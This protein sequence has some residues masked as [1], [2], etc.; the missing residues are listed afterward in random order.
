[1][2]R[3][4]LL[5]DSFAQHI[6]T[7]VLTGMLLSACALNA[8]DNASPQTATTMT[9]ATGCKPLKP[10]P[11]IG[12]LLIKESG[13]FHM[14]ESFSQGWIFDIHA[15]AYKGPNIPSMIHGEAA[16]VEIDLKSK[17]LKTD[18]YVS[19]IMVIAARYNPKGRNVPLESNEVHRVI[20]RNGTIQLKNTRNVGNGFG[21]ILAG[22]TNDTLKW[23]YYG[24]N[25]KDYGNPT[26]RPPFPTTFRK[27]QY[28]LENLTIKTAN[29]A[30]LM[31][32][33][34]IVIR[35]C[36]IEVENENALIIYG[37]NALIENNTIVYKFAA[38]N[39]KTILRTAIYLNRANNAV[40]RNNTISVDGG[41]AIASMVAMVDSKDVRIENNLLKGEAN[42]AVVQ[43]TS[44]AVLKGNRIK[45][46][47]FKSE[48]QLPDQTLDALGN[49]QK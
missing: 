19:G 1:M 22:Q 25:L 37:P 48:R 24:D 13:C 14:E 32:G 28:V 47:V 27:V 44:S 21:V 15:L 3:H 18:T 49:T 11:S 42:A 12:I 20:I 10:N 17:E 29:A 31:M 41:E 8:Q 40:I 30:A 38:G 23:Y 16:D 5:L 43:G 7:I 2:L 36:T 35:N 6:L 39:P 4:T 46:G 26:S 45:E 33:D 34:G 9:P